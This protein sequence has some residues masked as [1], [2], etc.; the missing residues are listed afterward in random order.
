[1]L[2]KLIPLLGMRVDSK[3]I[4]DIFTE[5]NAIF[6]KRVTCTA[7]EPNIKGKVE[8]NCVRLYFGRGGNSR[9]LKPIPASWEGG[10]FGIFTMIEFTKKRKGDMPFGVEFDMES[11]EL[12]Q[13]LGEPK[14]VEFMGTTT[15]WR[16]NITDKHEFIV[17]DTLSTDGSS[18]RSMTVS[19]VYEPDLYTME[20]YKKAGL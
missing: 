17:S 13:I 9:Y 19:F 15:T 12:T 14:I 2:D 1:M 20:E 5:W 16:K 7:N 3:E 18:L 8:K 4:K 11:E 10:Y 6:P